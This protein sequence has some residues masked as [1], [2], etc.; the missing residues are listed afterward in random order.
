MVNACGCG[1]EIAEKR[2]MAAPW[3]TQCIQC[4]EEAE[5]QT[6]PQL[7]FA[8]VPKEGYQEYEGED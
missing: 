2:L 8:G 1:K 6:A 3:A 4:Q 7:V 5:K